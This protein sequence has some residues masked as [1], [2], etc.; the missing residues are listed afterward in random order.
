MGLVLIA[1]WLPKS[2]Q[3]IGLDCME[4]SIATWCHFSERERERERDS[5]VVEA[6]LN[7]SLFF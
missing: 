2:P 5:R 3:T 4:A 1:R 6:N 7:A